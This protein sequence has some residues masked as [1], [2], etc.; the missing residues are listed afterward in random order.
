M[1]QHLR[2]NPLPVT[3]DESYSDFRVWCGK[4]GVV[5][6]KMQYVRVLKVG[7][8]TFWFMGDRI[9]NTWVGNADRVVSLSA[10]E[11]PSVQGGADIDTTTNTSCQ[12]T[13]RQF[14]VGDENVEKRAQLE[15]VEF[16]VASK[17][18]RKR[19]QVETPRI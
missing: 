12:W 3:D 7:N 11:Y 5:R 4:N 18:G 15:T 1:S 19:S 14:L 9:C 10:F 16:A 17:M 13:C 6:M 8:V 2:T